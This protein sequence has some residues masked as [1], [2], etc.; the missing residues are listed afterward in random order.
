MIGKA[1]SFI[2]PYSSI[3]SFNAVGT[4]LGFVFFREMDLLLVPY[5]SDPS[6]KLIQWPPFLLAGKV[7]AVS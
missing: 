2:S 4:K 1:T 6:L 7:D 5:S 3:S